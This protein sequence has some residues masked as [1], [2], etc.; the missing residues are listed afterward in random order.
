VASVSWGPRICALIIAQVWA[1]DDRVGHGESK[2]SENED[3]EK[4]AGGEIERAMGQGDRNQGKESDAAENDGNWTF[5]E[6]EEKRPFIGSELKVHRLAEIPYRLNGPGSTAESVEI[7][8]ADNHDSTLNCSRHRRT[9]RKSLE[10][11][12]KI[13]I[14][15]YNFVRQGMNAVGSGRNFCL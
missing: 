9:L 8:R 13:Y 10:M 6:E 7:S 4:R 5:I 15:I 2:G 3:D 12:P 1:Y 14:Y 11:S